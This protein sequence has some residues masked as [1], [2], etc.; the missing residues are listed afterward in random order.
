MKKKVLTLNLQSSSIKDKLVIDWS[1][2]PAAAE[3]SVFNIAHE[4]HEI[5]I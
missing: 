2:C 5:N 4:I 1:I 3:L